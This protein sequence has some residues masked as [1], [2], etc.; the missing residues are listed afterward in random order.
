MECL[1]TILI[2]SVLAS[3]IFTGVRVANKQ[4]NSA[5]CFSNLR[6]IGAAL[7]SYAA[8]NGE[9]PPAYWIEGGAAP[10]SL[11]RNGGS[12]GLGYLITGGYLG[13]A[14]ED[15]TG[16]NRSNVLRCPSKN[17]RMI[18]GQENWCSYAYQNPVSKPNGAYDPT[19]PSRPGSFRAGL[20]MVMDT[21]QAYGGWPPTHLDKY[22]NVLYSDGHA[23]ARLAL[24]R[25]GVLPKDFDLT[26]EPRP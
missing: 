3:L 25:G 23:E 7:F 20:G 9:L 21:L 5:S 4:A 1:I 13:P 14:Y 24:D 8:D 6:Q 16:A 12:N 26:G 19:R 10:A 15:P 22:T 11:N 2:V 17:G 18:W